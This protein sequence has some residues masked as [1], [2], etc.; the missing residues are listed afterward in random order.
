MVVTKANRQK[1]RRTRKKGIIYGKAAYLKKRQQDLKNGRSIERMTG[2]NNGT[3]REVTANRNKSGD[4]EMPKY[5]T[6]NKRK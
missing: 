6:K 5:E 4:I 1:A 3:E 2:R